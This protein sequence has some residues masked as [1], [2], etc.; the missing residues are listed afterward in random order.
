MINRKVISSFSYP[1][2]DLN[3][4]LKGMSKFVGR[5]KMRI[6]Q[7]L[8]LVTLKDRVVLRIPGQEIYLHCAPVGFCKSSLY[9]T[10]LFDA[11]KDFKA[12]VSNFEIGDRD[13]KLNN[14]ML[15]SEAIEINPEDS[16]ILQGLDLGT[17]NEEAYDAV[18][19]IKHEDFI[20]LQK[21]GWELGH[22]NDLKKDVEKARTF[23][24]KYGVTTDELLQLVKTNLKIK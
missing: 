12:E 24:E 16:A 10:E 1:T 7:K 2:K 14:R 13:T 8:E 22:I 9:F 17:L 3:I 11:I 21:N 4:A 20:F 19:Y 5:G 23:L 6:H 15:T 18:A